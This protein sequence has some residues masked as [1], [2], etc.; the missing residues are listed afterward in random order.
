MKK[1]FLILTL[2]LSILF[3]STTVNAFTTRQKYDNTVT[4]DYLDESGEYTSCDGLLTQEGLDM[5]KE[6]L[7]WI[8][9]IAPILLILFVAIDLA[10]AVI[11]QDNDAI[12]KA[13]KKIIPRLIG[14]ALLFFVPTIIRA[15]LNIDGV[16][17]SIVIP[18]DP[19]CHTMTAVPQ[20]NNS[21]YLK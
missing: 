5:I 4:I 9:I 11:S 18:D 12:G 19:L 6:I 15:I 20:D 21:K 10:S 13:T 2:I 17:E 3:C 16:R 14:T 8:R 1:T 7:G